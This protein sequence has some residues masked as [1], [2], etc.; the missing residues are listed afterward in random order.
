MGVHSPHCRHVQFTGDPLIVGVLGVFTLTWTG[1]IWI[2][3]NWKTYYSN[4]KCGKRPLLCNTSVMCVSVTQFKQLLNKQHAQVYQSGWKQVI[5]TEQKAV[6]AA[7]LASLLLCKWKDYA[8]SRTPGSSL[9]GSGGLSLDLI[10][11][12]KSLNTCVGIM[13]QHMLFFLSANTDQ[14]GDPAV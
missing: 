3:V 6:N 8:T 13:C 5:S 12:H 9:P 10:F 14:W 11:Q 4:S 1:A 7:F 2:K